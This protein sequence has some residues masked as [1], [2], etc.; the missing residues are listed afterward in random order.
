MGVRGNLY[1]IENISIKLFLDT[2]MVKSDKKL[3]NSN[4]YKTALVTTYSSCIYLIMTNAWLLDNQSL[5]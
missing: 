3:L 1:Y 5:P 4:I 2:P